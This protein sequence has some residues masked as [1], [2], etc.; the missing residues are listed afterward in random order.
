[1]TLGIAKSGAADARQEKWYRTV[2]RWHFYAGLF[3]MPFILWLS[4]TG[5]LY[6]FKPQIERWI[7]SPYNNLTITGA[8]LAPSVL[9]ERAQAVVPG[10]VLHRF[11]LPEEA[12]DAQQIVVGVGPDE[13]RVYLHP[14]TGEVLKNVGEQDRFMRVVLHLHGELMMGRWGSTLVELA[15]SWTIVMLITGLFLWWPRDGKGLGGVLYPRLSRSG[16]NWWKDIHAV[17]GMWVTLFAALLI[18][19]GLPWAQSWGNYLATMREM[20]GQVEGPVDWSRGSDAEREER[21]ALDRHARVSMGAHAAHH[22]MGTMGGMQAAPS[23]AAQLDRV[24]PTATRLNLPAPVEIT[25][26]VTASGPW[27]AVSNTANRPQRSTAEINGETG[28]LIGRVDFAERHW[29]DRVVGYG[30]AWHEGA[31]F[32]LAN[33]LFALAILIALVTLSLSGALM[34]WRRRPDGRLGAPAPKG[35]IR[36]SWLLVGLTVVLAFVVPLFGF[37]LAL[38]ILIERC[39]RRSSTVQSFLGLRSPSVNA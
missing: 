25:P 27:K 35:I 4:C 3:T 1:M 24:V 10:S 17:T 6:L 32:G 39:G 33:Q 16:R 22:G 5:A 11:I 9:V 29:I 18:F 38:V 20:T 28:A 36:H 13:T 14:H 19:T 34:W 2:W 30:V 8:P 37:S 26:P 7:D 21:A 31:L 23:M 12:D 15:A